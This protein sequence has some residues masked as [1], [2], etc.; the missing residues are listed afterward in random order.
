MF[1]RIGTC[2]TVGSL[3]LLASC[4]GGGGG[5]S[6]GGNGN[7]T[8]NGSDGI[9]SNHLPSS[10]GTINGVFLDSAIS[11]INYS[12]GSTNAVTDGA[13]SFTCQAGED[14][15]FKL[16][17]IVIGKAPCLPVITPIELAT[18]GAVRSSSVTFSGNIADQLSVAQNHK[19]QRLTMFLQTIDSDGNLSNGISPHAGSEVILQQILTA[20]NTTLVEALADG[21]VDSGFQDAL[22]EF[23]ANSSPAH[24]SVNASDAIAHFS[25]TLSSQSICSVGDVSNSAS[26]LGYAPN[27]IALTCAIGYSVSDGSCI[28][29]TIT[30]FS[31]I[32]DFYNNFVITWNAENYDPQ[33]GYG[34][35]TFLRKQANGQVIIPNQPIS[36][37]MEYL[38]GHSAGSSSHCNHSSTVPYASTTGPNLA[39]FYL[40][41]TYEELLEDIL[42]DVKGRA[43]NSFLTAPGAGYEAGRRCAETIAT[44]IVK[45]GAM[46]SEQK[47]SLLNLI[48]AT[49]DSNF[50][51]STD[52]S[53]LSADELAILDLL[54]AHYNIQ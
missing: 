29:D 15:T 21:P 6:S 17:S 2:M 45:Y 16:G 3:L 19:L 53:G 5:S 14:I 13:G 22:N 4:L 37:F 8:P 7:G 24:V 52:G 31:Q 30:S 51:I 28:S 23:V 27:C 18:L 41:S 40:T 39:G 42:S 46:S 50:V 20:S 47:T 35:G 9:T 43:T 25:S 38:V 12:T 32:M 49:D 11:G 34:N 36:E 44:Q 33:S 48:N 26:V 54:I 1:K 10:L